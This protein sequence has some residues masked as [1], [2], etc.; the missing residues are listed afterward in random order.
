M[1]SRCPSPGLKPASRRGFTIVELLVVVSLLA[2]LGTFT[3]L[4][5][6]QVRQ[7]GNRV[8]SANNLRQWG[9]AMIASLPD[10]ANIMPADGQGATPLYND[11]ANAW[12]NVLPPYLNLKPLGDLKKEGRLPRP[13]ERSLWINP[14]V[15]TSV[16]ND[17]RSDFFCYAVNY[18]MTDNSASPN[19]YVHAGRIPYPASTVFMGEKNDNFANLSPNY[20]RG[21]FGNA[22]TIN[23]PEALA[24]FVFC[25]GHV[26]LVPRKRFS[27]ALG[28]PTELDPPQPGL[29][30]FRPYAG[31][32]H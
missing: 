32:K 16:G 12:F 18:F 11:Y 8:V 6:R 13:G 24:H 10:R 15:P 28:A 29:I 19:T 27:P 17:F 9:Q 3:F 5:S 14:A 21:Y 31:A 4:A 1:T 26:E 23:S 20:V 25:D 2:V 7:A 30:N 22:L